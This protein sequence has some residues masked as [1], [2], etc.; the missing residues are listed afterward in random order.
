MQAYSNPLNPAI[1]GCKTEEKNMYIAW[2]VGK[3]YILTCVYVYVCRVLYSK[4]MELHTDGKN[5]IGWSE[6]CSTYDI[7]INNKL[8]TVVTV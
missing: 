5:C 4:Y 8:W 6:I 1:I 2:H 3:G 7:V